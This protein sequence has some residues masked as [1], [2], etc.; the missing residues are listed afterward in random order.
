MQTI[1]SGNPAVPSLKAKI[2]RFYDLGSPYYLQVFGCHIHDGYYLTGKE[3]REEAQENLIRFLS[4]K[5]DIRP[6]STILDVG[7]GIGGSS[8]WLAQQLQA[9]T[10]GITISPVQVDIARQLARDRNV[11]S[12]FLL[13]D[14]G[15]MSF[16]QTFD[17]IWIVA[18]LT[19]LVDQEKFLKSSLKFLE[20]G[21]K[22]IIYDWTLDDNL[23]KLTDDPDIEAVVDGMV[24]SRLYPLDTYLQWLRKI[25]SRITYAE[26]I[27][28]HTLK[29]WDGA[30]S[31][32]T[33]PGVWKMLLQSSSAERQEALTFLR[34]ARAIKGA[35]QKGKV[36]SVVIIAENSG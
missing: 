27:T 33:D 31:I 20:P 36:R 18:A 9:K 15:D 7:S 11:D 12:R 1:S 13:M 32:L 6:G 22:L 10:T 2:S 24:L 34:G 35:M 16:L 19:H 30:L 28:E 3:T 14:A 23:S 17:Y 4:A 8:I 29:T 25:G 5:A 21:G 26:D